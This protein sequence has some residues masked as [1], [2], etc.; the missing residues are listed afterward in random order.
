MPRGVPN[1]G[2]RKP[3]MAAEPEV[4]QSPLAIGAVDAEARAETPAEV[5]APPPDVP[6]GLTDLPMVELAPARVDEVHGE[7][8]TAEQEEIKRLRDQVATLSGKKD[9]PPVYEQLLRPGAEGN[10]VIHFLED[11][12]TALGQVWYRGQELEFEP[13]SRAYKDTFNRLGRSWLELAGNDFAQV[14]KWGKV[15]FRPGPWPGKSY[16]DGTFEAMAD[17]DGSRV[18][19]PTPEELAKADELRRTQR[20][21]PRLPQ[22]V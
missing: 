15:M 5:P 17:N 7:P 2:Q 6:D 16:L 11:G 1:S 14:E 3:R 20:A 10:I 4:A 9:E 18:S 19:P 21:A 12:L 13:H 8:L 22:Q